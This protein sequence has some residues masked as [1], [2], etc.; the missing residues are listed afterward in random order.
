MRAFVRFVKITI[1]GCCAGCLIATIS[2]LP[3][4]GSITLAVENPTDIEGQSHISAPVTADA[5][6]APHANAQPDP[7]LFPEEE[8][9]EGFVSLR[10]LDWE[11]NAV[12]VTEDGVI[13]LYAD[14][15]QPMLGT[16]VS[17]DGRTGGVVPAGDAVS[18]DYFNDAIMVGNS[19]SVGLQKSG[20]LG[21]RYYADIG[22]TVN[23]F[24]EQSF[25]SDPLGRTDENDKVLRVTAAEALAAVDTSYTKVYLMFGLNELGWASP[26]AL[27]TRYEEVI[28]TILSIRPDTVI[29]VQSIFPINEELHLETDPDS[30][31]FTNERISTFNA[32]LSDMAER[33]QV[34]YLDVASA[35]ADETG[36][37]PAHATSDG[38]HLQTSALQT[39]AEYLRTHTV[40]PAEET[41]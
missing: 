15:V 1:T 35:L 18:D 9:A 13:Y 11:G 36:S 32:A 21:M 31:Y 12:T 30:T 39:W 3:F 10:P 29:Y 14:E 20:I 4:G 25:L 16:V 27:V 8:V 41:P 37:L 26:N 24:F 5:C 34:Y 17:A 19:L 2:T 28:D 22:L 6:E 7:A 40:T 38:V 23:H 33:K